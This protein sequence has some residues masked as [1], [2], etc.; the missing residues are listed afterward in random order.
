MNHFDAIAR[1]WDQ[2]P[3]RFERSKTIAN[4]LIASIPLNNKMRALEYGAGTGILS[5]MLKDQFS[6]IMM[7]DSSAEMVNVMLEKIEPTGFNHLKPMFL[8]LEDTPYH[9][10]PFDLVYSLLVMH[11]IQNIDLVLARFADM[12]KPGGYVVLIDLF[13]EDGSFHG[14]DFD[15]HNGFEPDF[16]TKKLKESGFHQISYKHCHSIERQNEAGERREYPLF[17]MMAKR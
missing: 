3:E 15:G 6:E 16:L 10:K 1:Q 8:N 17:L 12:I 5:I 9:D 13:A 14:A 11:H 7:M 2:N 4:E